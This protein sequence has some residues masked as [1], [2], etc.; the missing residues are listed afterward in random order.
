MF[1]WI[2]KANK[3]G[4]HWKFNPDIGEITVNTGEM[5]CSCLKLN[6]FAEENGKRLWD[7]ALK[8]TNLEHEHEDWFCGRKADA[9]F[10]VFHDG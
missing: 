9:M 1:W 7:N 2:G 10:N 4:H 6:A 8:R 3:K 5:F